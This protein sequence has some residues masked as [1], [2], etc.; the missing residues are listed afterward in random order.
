LTSANFIACHQWE[1]LQQLDL[2]K[3]ARWLHLSAQ[4]PLRSSPGN[5]DARLPQTMQQQIIDQGLQVYA[6][7]A[8]NVARA[9]VWVTAS[10]P[11]C[12]C[13]SSPSPA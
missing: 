6:I 3:D 5:L 10:T 9:L 1:F 7:N 4:Q 8:Y 13:A 2:L 11:S 12:R